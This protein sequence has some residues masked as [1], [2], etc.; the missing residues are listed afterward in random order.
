MM[1]ATGFFSMAN[2]RRE[3]S[4]PNFLARVSDSLLFILEFKIDTKLQPAIKEINVET[5][6]QNLLF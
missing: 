6:S 5:C 3:V 4:P 2:R 1:R